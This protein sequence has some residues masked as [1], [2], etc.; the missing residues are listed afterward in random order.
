MILH[1]DQHCRV[2]V[3]DDNEAIH[4]DFKKI[5]G[6]ISAATNSL[7]EAAAELFGQ[8]DLSQPTIQFEIE[9]ADQG[10]NG[11]A[12]VKRAIDEGRP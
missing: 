1:N 10:R 6:G 12:M 11:L 2:L 9:S 7:D 3:V 8:P 4:D 5:L